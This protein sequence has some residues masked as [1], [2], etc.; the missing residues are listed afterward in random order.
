MGCGQEK[1]SQKLREG[2]ERGD[3]QKER[4]STAT[5]SVPGGTP[6]R[7]R[8][9][10]LIQAI[11]GFVFSGQGS[12]AAGAFL[13]RGRRFAL[14]VCQMNSVGSPTSAGAVINLSTVLRYRHRRTADAIAVKTDAA[15]A[16][17]KTI[18]ATPSPSVLD[19]RATLA[20][21]RPYLR[22]VLVPSR[23]RMI[24]PFQ[25]FHS[26]FHRILSGPS[27]VACPA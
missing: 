16:S 5:E 18:T 1:T 12:R 7:S 6:Q 22:R 13:R 27:K 24:V 19:P 9:C 8:A 20:W 21:R 11:A 23:F 3:S 26:A 4:C 25:S 14:R 2:E 15:S 10:P 17:M